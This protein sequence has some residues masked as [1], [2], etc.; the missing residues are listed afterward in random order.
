MDSENK[1]RVALVTG[2][3]GFIGSHLVRRL[4][5]EQWEVHIVTRP[6]SSLSLLNDIT[7][8]ITQHRYDFTS[9]SLVDIVGA[10]Q[11]D[12]VFHLASLFLAN[13]SVADIRPL[14]E[15]NVLMGAQLLEAM[16]VHHVRRLVNT[17]TSWQHF[18]NASYNPVCLYAATKQA[19]EA[20][21]TYYVETSAIQVITLSLF[22][23]YG[24]HDPRPKLLNQL[25]AAMQANK[26]LLM[27]PGEQMIDLVHV[28]DVVEAYVLAA[29]RLQAPE[30]EGHAEYAV[31]SG[32][33]IRL[34][35][36]VL[37]YEEIVGATIPIVWGGRPYRD[38][39]VMAPW[40]TGNCLPGW[41]PRISLREGL[42]R[43]LKR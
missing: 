21:I 36:L 34:R 17:G 13:H 28:D 43:L 10:T 4:L 39:E 33:P 2:A 5:K 9:E 25:R 20:I 27:S 3:T 31:A 16:R 26:P 7:G 42:T 32:S 12:V 41:T 14:I 40:G 19:F 23:T 6:Q 30:C 8:E 38:R 22:D 24:E 1:A 18:N 29:E 11:P 15:S 35:D 37:L